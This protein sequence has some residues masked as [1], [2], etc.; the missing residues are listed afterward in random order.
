M[1]N[2]ST[3]KDYG[4][5]QWQLR[6]VLAL[7]FTAWSGFGKSRGYKPKFTVL[8]ANQTLS[9]D[10]GG[11]RNVIMD[12]F[13]VNDWKKLVFETLHHSVQIG[14][15]ASCFSKLRGDTLA[16]LV[17]TYAVLHERAAK[18]G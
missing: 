11:T 2:G 7:V 12:D 13:G 17:R 16:V 9:C 3:V 5:L 14:F 8:M 10:R 4:D 6:T 18:T 1:S 15:S